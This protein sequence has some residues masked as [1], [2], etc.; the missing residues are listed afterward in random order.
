MIALKTLIKICFIFLLAYLTFSGN[1]HAQSGVIRG[2]IYEKETG[3]PIIFTNVYLK[4]TSMGAASDVNGYFIITPIPPGQ[5]IL[6]VTYLGYDTLNMPITIHQDDFITK[7]LFLSKAAYMLEGVSISASKDE[8]LTETRVSTLTIT[9]KQIKQIPAIGGQPDL[10]QY[11]QVVPGVVYTGDQGG[12]LYIR[13][14]S[15]VQNKVLLDGMVIYNP[16]HSIGLFS[17]FETDII[18]S[19]DIFTGGFGAEYGGRISSVID[20][21][22]RDGNKRR[23]AGKVSASTFAADALLEGPLKKL[24]ENGKGSSSFILSA[25]HSYLDQSSKIFYQ[26]VDTA[27]LPF[28]YTDL[29]GKISLNGINGSK[30]NFFGFHHDDKVNEYHALANYHWIS[31]G[32]GM[33]FVV[34]P[35]RTPALMEGY[36]SYSDY[37]ISL[38]EKVSPTRSSR[39]GGFEMG[40]NFSYFF[41]KDLFKYGIEMLGYTTVFDYYNSLNRKIEQKENTTELGVFVTYKKVLNKLLIEPGFRLQWYASLHNISPEPRLAI[42]YNVAAN[43]RLK[44]AGGFYSQNLI[45]AKSD[46]DVVNLF[47]AFVS[48]PDNLPHEFD[49]KE[50]THKLQK[51]SH[52]IF[53]VE[54]DI[55]KYLT[56]NLEGYYKKF[57]QL[58]NL[59]RNKIFNDDEANANQ[60]DYLKKDFI[61]ENGHAEGIDV[62][63]K[64]DCK[65]L[66]IWA[67]YSLAYVQ[68]Y[69]GIIEYY[70]HYDRRHNINLV[71]TYTCGETKSWEASARCNM[72]SGFP[73]TQTQ[74]FYE[75]L[76]FEGG[77]NSNYTA[78]NGQLGIIYAELNA[79][80][81][82]N[83]FRMDVNLK[84]IFLTGYHSRLE[85]NVGI[86]N[87]FDRENIFYVDR[88]SYEKVYQLPLMPSI[89]LKF[90][91]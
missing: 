35:G 72:G 13:G 68:L 31:S 52:L 73:F 39:I 45:S 86:T 46:R 79:G 74:G 82:P 5:Y 47:Y 62:S 25:K 15:P 26:Y 71:M 20:I 19:M 12:Q 23:M 56:M 7:K 58:T 53:G 49:G 67:V 2:F 4:N 76:T 18:R 55:G 54:Y 69:D 61:I 59:N 77:V 36:V 37:K 3:E 90:V 9:P 84:R 87:I 30:V 89:G 1:V 57:N 29:Y 17:V 65:Q 32:G 44:F 43:L 50:V 66:Y 63:F 41:N 81:L 91:F 40:L 8:A 6:A 42:K 64:Y 70:P 11:L 21:T 27:G 24:K 16:F 60:P 22:T 78:E 34:I 51:A 28:T 88:I 85:A 75:E 48:G 33:N 38:E 10:A 80:R 83:Y 14:G